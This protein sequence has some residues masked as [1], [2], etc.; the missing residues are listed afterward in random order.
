MDACKLQKAKVDYSGGVEEI[1][2]EFRPSDWLSIDF[3]QR[4]PYFPQLGDDLVYFRQGHELY[5]KN[6]EDKKLYQIPKKMKKSFPYV[7]KPELEV[8]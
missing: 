7:V 4:S 2:P 1:A 8:I 3:P 5:I 6:V